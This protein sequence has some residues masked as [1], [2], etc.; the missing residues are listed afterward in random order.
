MV[1]P[2]LPAKCL[3]HREF[4]HSLASRS[5]A[6]LE[7]HVV[8]FAFSRQSIETLRDCLANGTELQ[9]KRVPA[10]TGTQ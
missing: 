5:H 7:G 9:I 4:L 10:I 3:V 2:G 1:M 8:P 6:H